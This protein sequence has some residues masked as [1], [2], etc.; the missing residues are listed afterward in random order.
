MD[1]T[2]DKGAR[3]TKEERPMIISRKEINHVI[4]AYAGRDTTRAEGRAPAVPARG[5]TRAD[6][7]D[8]SERV[9]QMQRVQ[10]IAKA[11]PDIRPDR[12]GPIKVALA[13]GSYK[14][15]AE[16]IAEK[17]LGRSIVDELA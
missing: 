5:A 2:Q 17:I 1:D 3:G 8:L 11:A 4:K 6:K 16:D 7:V 10:E 15:S 14:V 9:R 13:D 12:V